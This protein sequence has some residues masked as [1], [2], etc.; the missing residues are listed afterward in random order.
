MKLIERAIGAVS[1]QWALARARARH[2]A[3]T[4][5]HHLDVD[6]RTTLPRAHLRRYEGAGR[7]RRFEGWITPGGGPNT[8][9]RGA[10]EI[11]RA[12]ARDLVRNDQWASKAVRVL[13]S[14]TIGTGIRPQARPRDR[15]NAREKANALEAM[16]LWGEWAES[17]ECDARG[18]R[19][20]YG[21]QKV[22]HREVAEAGECLVR[23]RFRR[24]SDPLAVP[25]QLEVLEA[26]HLDATRDRELTNGG[27]VIQGVQY[28]PIGAVEGYWLY[29]EHP[30]DS[31]TM[32]PSRFVR[33]ADVL[34]VFREDRAG[35][36]RGVP[37]GS[38]CILKLRDL[39]ELDDAEL[40]RRKIASCFVGFVKDGELGIDGDQSAQPTVAGGENPVDLLGA[41][42]IEILPPGKE[43]TFASPPKAEGY[44]E[45]VQIQLRAVSAG[46]GVTYEAL[47]GDLSGVN[48]TS[49]RMGWL[50][51]WAEI[52][53]FQHLEF[54]PVICTPIWRW[55]T[56]AAVDAR[57][58]RE[59]V[60]ARWT[61]PRR[62]Y[63]DPRRE[64]L[65]QRD[66][67]RSGLTSAPEEIR[68]L[69]RDPRELL[70]EAAE[71]QAEA[72]ELGLVLDTDLSGAA[73]LPGAASSSGTRELAQEL[74][75]LI[76]EGGRG[77]EDTEGE[78]AERLELLVAAGRNGHARP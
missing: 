65:A 78:I 29:P 7:G 38:C 18:R 5:N 16:Y 17:R 68:A 31:T 56:E 28:T 72:E 9:V 41:G 76:A 53:Q 36:V 51:M 46:Y 34:H 59:H 25:I 45:H 67:I 60:A 43:M 52:L 42:T 8:E 14:R 49:G 74:A 69:G 1:P 54:L 22:V 44:A 73:N 75:A 71:F 66:G 10:L 40:L 19:N 77:L 62:P 4:I 3:D 35:Q 37:W 57:K 30:G 24:P 26:D 33:A 6:R 11:L 39:D 32:R 12:R 50:E 70:E 15:K 47:T 13:S 55:F 20:L 23:R 21:L 64:V 27:R 61:M 48:F 63:L 2:A 58:L